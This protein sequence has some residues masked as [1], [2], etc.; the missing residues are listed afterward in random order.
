MGEPSE[1]I[2]ILDM[3]IKQ[4]V[5]ASARD[6]TT[7]QLRPLHRAAMTK[8]VSATM[9]LLGKDPDMVN[10]GDVEG[11]TALLHACSTPSQKM[12]LVE[13]LVHKK[14]NFGGMGRPQMPDHDGQA[15]ARYLDEQGIE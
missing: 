1:T 8:N 9:F 14:A 2:E 3:L 12:A 7:A 13:E 6:S 11:K 10:L 5:E 4:G 15:I